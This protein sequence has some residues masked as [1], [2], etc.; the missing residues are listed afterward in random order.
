MRY[1]VLKNKNY[2]YAIV[3]PN[4]KSVF[5]IIPV[6]LVIPLGT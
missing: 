4:L 5:K 1:F 6:I 2:T 3:D